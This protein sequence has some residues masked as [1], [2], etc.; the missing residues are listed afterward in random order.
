MREDQAD[1]LIAAI[2]RNTAAVLGKGGTT[3]STKPPVKPPTSGTG[4]KLTFD[5][6]KAALVQVRDEKGKPAAQKIIKTVGKADESANID[7]KYYRAVVAAC[8]T[9]LT[10]D[11]DPAE[12]AGGGEEDTL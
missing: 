1:Q 2:D 6:V 4:T 11:D 3:G 12:D 9:L 8:K 7:E 10:P 5:M